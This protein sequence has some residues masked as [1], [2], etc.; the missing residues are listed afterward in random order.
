MLIILWKDINVTYPYVYFNEKTRLL[1]EVR[2]EHKDASY[3]E[4]SEFAANKG[5][6]MSKS[7]VV[8]VF[9]KIHEDALR[10]QKEMSSTEDK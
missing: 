10:I 3:Q 1:A 2:M 4:L 6:V 7:G 5:L 8:H 9:K